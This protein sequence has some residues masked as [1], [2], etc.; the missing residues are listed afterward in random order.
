MAAHAEGGPDGV[1]R[2]GIQRG[3]DEQPRGQAH[4]GRQLPEGEAV[5]RRCRSDES[6]DQAREL[7]FYGQFLHVS[8]LIRPV[9]SFRRTIHTTVVL[10]LA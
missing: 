6:P 3:H 1:P 2:S 10:V 5:R 4:R 7:Y 8:T 9:S